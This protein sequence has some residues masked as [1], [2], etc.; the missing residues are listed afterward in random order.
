MF[1]STS[2]QHDKPLSEPEGDIKAVI[3]SEETDSARL[4][5][6]RLDLK[7]VGWIFVDASHAVIKH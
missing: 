6:F 2:S 3:G 7:N 4:V 5:D 1:P